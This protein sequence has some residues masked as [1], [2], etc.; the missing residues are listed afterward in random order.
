MFTYSFLLKI[1]II[2]VQ[3]FKDSTFKLN[4]QNPTIHFHPFKHHFCQNPS[5]KLISNLTNLTIHFHS[6]QY[7][8][9]QLITLFYVYLFIS[10]KKISI[11]KV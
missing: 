7:R 6:F 2:K 4:F 3:L 1:P 11:T 9:D 8:F 5:F 10:L